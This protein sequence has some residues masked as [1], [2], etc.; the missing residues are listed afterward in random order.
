MEKRE[1]NAM[2]N[3]VLIGESLSMAHIP[4]WRIG[5][6]FPLALKILRE[7]LRLVVHNH[8]E[9]YAIGIHEWII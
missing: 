4:S 5:V 9:S 8:I 2:K 6:L 3:L 7:G 1:F